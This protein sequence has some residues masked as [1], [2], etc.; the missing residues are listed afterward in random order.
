LL[1][2]AQRPKEI[3]N[4]YV[5]LI[6]MLNNEDLLLANIF[7]EYMEDSH[8]GDIVIISFIFSVLETEEKITAK[9]AVY[10]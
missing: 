7:Y 3:D 10:V 9:I 8:D 1:K 5:R 2:I 4:P 6:E